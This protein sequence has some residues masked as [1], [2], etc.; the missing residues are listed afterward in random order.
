[1]LVGEFGNSK[2]PN[3]Y[4]PVGTILEIKNVVSH[5]GLV[6]YPFTTTVKISSGKMRGKIVRSH[7]LFTFNP[8]PASDDSPWLNTRMAEPVADYSR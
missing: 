6:S 7:F 1:M 5:N 2:N 8:D 4:L 3:D